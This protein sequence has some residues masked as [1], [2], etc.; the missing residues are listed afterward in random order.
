MRPPPQIVE[1]LL[2]ASRSIAAV[3]LAWAYAHAIQSDR[4]LLGACRVRAD[5]PPRTAAGPERNRTPEPVVRGAVA[6]AARIQPDSEDVPRDQRRGLRRDRR[7][8]RTRPGYA[9]RVGSQGG[10]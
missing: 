9:A 10:H 7:L 4:G 8:L 1:P 3:G 6:G 5:A 2:T